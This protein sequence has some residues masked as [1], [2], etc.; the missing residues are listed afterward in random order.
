MTTISKEMLAQ[1]EEISSAGLPLEQRLVDTAIWFH[2]NKDRLPRHDPI[3]RLDFMEK[4]L[5][6]TLEIN[7]MLVQRMQKAEGRRNSPLWLP[8]GIDVQGDIRKFG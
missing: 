7:A 4:M 1:L 6:I 5:D 8:A 3:K 2:N